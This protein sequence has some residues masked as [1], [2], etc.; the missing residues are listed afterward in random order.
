MKG[1]SVAML[2]LAFSRLLSIRF[3][4]SVSS[5]VCKCRL[6]QESKSLRL[7]YLPKFALEIVSLSPVVVHYEQVS[8]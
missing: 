4:L 3:Y 7:V 8:S 5:K 6:S 2:S 1:R